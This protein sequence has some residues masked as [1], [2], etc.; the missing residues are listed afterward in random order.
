MGEATENDSPCRSEHLARPVGARAKRSMGVTLGSAQDQVSMCELLGARGSAGLN[1]RPTL[2]FIPQQE[3]PL[4]GGVVDDQA[5]PAA[6]VR[7][8]AGPR[9]NTP[10]E[11]R[12]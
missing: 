5:G 8:V 10:G 6:G 12:R 4:L 7:G 11:E 2:C 1:G 3:L 9:S